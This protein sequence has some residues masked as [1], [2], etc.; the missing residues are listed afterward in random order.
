MTTRWDFDVVGVGFGPSNLS[1]AIAVEEHNNAAPHSGRPLRA[2]FF[3]KQPAFAWHPG[4]LLEDATIQVSF[5][6]D[7]VTLRNPTSDYSFVAYL[8]ERGRLVDFINHHTLHP[9]RIEFNDYFRWAAERLTVPVRYSAEVHDVEPILDGDD[10]VG[11]AVKWGDRVVRTRNVVVASGL[12]PSVPPGHELS[13]RVWHNAQLLG[14]LQAMD[15]RSPSRFIVV[16]AGQSGAETAHHL[17][18]RFPGAEVVAVFATFGYTPADDSPFVN[19]IFDPGS[20]DLLFDAPESL[21]ERLFNV[22]RYTNYSA[23][24]RPLIEALYARLYRDKVAGASLF[25]VLNCSRVV[26]AEESADAVTVTV[27]SLADGTTQV[28]D[29]DAL[30][31]ATGYRP[32]DPVRLCAGMR[33]YCCLDDQGRLMVG[34]NY[35]VQL[36]RPAAGGLFVIGASEHSHGLSTTLL[37]N[38]AVRAGELLDAII[39]GGDP[40]SGSA[41]EVVLPTEALSEPV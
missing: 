38:M 16:G 3:E 31:F 40:D 25:R 12:V 32:A 17:L 26:A 28:I 20:V 23:V 21:R 15:G 41:A 1:L 18:G 37:S 29:A 33:P 5:L 39:A 35:Q 22:H 34:R 6:K 14:R 27:E 30:I 7:L 19:R 10:L 11:F 9:L 8:H 24:D 36:T 13:D 2:M 4:M